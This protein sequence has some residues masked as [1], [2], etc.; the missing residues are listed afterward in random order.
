MTQST[1]ALPV[2]PWTRATESASAIDEG[3]KGSMGSGTL[4]AGLKPSLNWF[5]VFIPISVYLEH[6]QAQAHLW[7]F[8]T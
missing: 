4:A 3:G 6:F 1:P 7:I 5:L 2:V 8:F